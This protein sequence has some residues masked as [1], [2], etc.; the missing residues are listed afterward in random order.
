MHS[1]HILYMMMSL[2]NI[3]LITYLRG[4]LVTK[5]QAEGQPVGL[6]SLVVC[7]NLNIQLRMKQLHPTS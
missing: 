2:K 3:S 4:V 1:K 6:T 7:H 5:Y